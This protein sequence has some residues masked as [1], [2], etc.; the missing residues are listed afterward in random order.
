MRVAFAGTPPFA[1]TALEAIRAAGHAVSLVLTQ[2]DRPAGRRGLR[3]TPSAVATTATSGGLDVI[4]P[5]T[6]RDP[7]AQQALREAAPEVLVVAAYGLLL[8]N[9]VLVIPRLGC[10]NIHASLLPRWRGAAPIQ[11]AILAGDLATGISIMQMDQGLDTGPVLLARS[12]PIASSD[13]A[14]SLTQALAALGAELVVEAL[15]C[16]D[17]LA[18]APQDAA[19]ATHAPKIA[20]AEAALD[21]NDSATNLERRV[22][23]FNP[24]PGAETRFAGET[25][26]VWEAHVTSGTGM[27]G[28]VISADVHGVV[29]ACGTGAL[30]LK[31]VQR[32]GGKSLRAGEF[33]RGAR[34]AA[35]TVFEP[36]GARSASGLLTR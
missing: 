16:L 23:A 24:A 20:K 13:T 34:L 32:A 14:G 22:R 6:L 3:L 9:E 35:G 8:P 36:V 5:T 25:I 21:W 1:A 2:P 17:A 27:A 7:A 33:A 4:K 10:I 18:P 19:L 29:V 30:V 28:Q 15:A 11:R 26:K 12:L 31:Q